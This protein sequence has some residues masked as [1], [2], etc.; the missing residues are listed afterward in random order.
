MGQQYFNKALSDFV[1]D[2]A[3]GGAIRHLADLGYTVKQIAETIDYPASQKQVAE[4]VWRYYLEQGMILLEE[5]SAG[6][7]LE[8]VT[9]VKEY[10]KYG[11]VHFRKVAEPVENGSAE[12]IPCDF[13]RKRYQD[14]ALFLKELECLEEQDRDY[15]LGLPWP[16]QRVWHVADKRMT[17]IMDRLS[18][19]AER[20][21]PAL[22]ERR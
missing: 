10:G 19:T 17:G 9:Y 2:M 14:E 3:N 7:A 20:T 5:P 1:K 22:P 15:I 16:L 12:Y 4:R 8:K 13:G 6:T 18:E 11:K 21:F